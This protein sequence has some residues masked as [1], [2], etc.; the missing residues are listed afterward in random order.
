MYPQIKVSRVCIYAPH[1]IIKPLWVAAII[2][3]TVVDKQVYQ[4]SARLALLSLCENDSAVLVLIHVYYPLFQVRK[5]EPLR[6][7]FR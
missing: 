4:F 5:S 2:V 1:H 3:G 6:S 7:K